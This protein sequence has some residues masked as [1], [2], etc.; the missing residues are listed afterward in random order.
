V[1]LRL[2]V[3]TEEWETRLASIA[4]QCPGLVPVVKGNG[5]G[6]GRGPLAELAAR[7]SDTVA[8]GTVHELDEIPAALVP[9]ILTPTL[10]PPPDRR[11]ILTIGSLAHVDA[12]RGWSGRV[13]V[14][15]A[16]SVHRF[17]VDPD[18]LGELVRAA[19]GADL[20]VVGFSVHPPLA[21]TDDEHLDE[22]AAWLRVLDPGDEVWVS[23]LTTAGY[24]DLL[25][26][27]PDRRFRI[28]LGSA[29]WHGEK[30][31]LHLTAD[32]LDL[33]PVRAG[34]PAGYRARPVPADGRIV[35]VGAG[36]AHG[37]QTLPDG[38]SPFHFAQRRLRLIEPPHMHVSMVLVPT[39]DPCPAIGEP[40]DVQV[41]L[42][43]S[44][45]DHIRWR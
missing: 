11:A 17:G 27:W 25:D 18:A 15:L 3:D 9:V 14:K 23:H 2:T 30:T 29:L 5:Y 34:E 21:G 20:E 26:A 6:F 13:L 36:T 7:F 39:G 40:V 19:D 8:V 37:M 31:A 32:V 12:I 42:I 16:S 22:I 24:R 43:Y 45:P 1:T 44:F 41:P 10:T 4:R 28:R 33:Q 38:R 35:V